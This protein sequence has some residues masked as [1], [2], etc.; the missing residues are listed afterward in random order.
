MESSIL[1]WGTAELILIL[2]EV[3]QYEYLF[4]Q[5]DL[6]LKPDILV[7]ECWFVQDCNGLTF[8]SW[9]ANLVFCH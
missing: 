1:E 5:K 4:C 6:N 7:A 8:Y 9:W 2:Q 3:L